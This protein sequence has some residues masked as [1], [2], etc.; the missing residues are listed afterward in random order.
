MVAI[1]IETNQL[2]WRADQL[3]GFY[4]LATLAFNELT[5]YPKIQ[6]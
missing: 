4:M 5:L 3:T 2:I 6:I 1:H